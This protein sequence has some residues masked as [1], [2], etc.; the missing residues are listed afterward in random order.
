MGG[1]GKTALLQVKLAQQLQDKFDFVVQ[2]SL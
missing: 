1:L 2:G